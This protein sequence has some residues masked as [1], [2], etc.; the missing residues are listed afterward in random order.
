MSKSIKVM[1]GVAFTAVL[2]L[3]LLASVGDAMA[4][5]DTSDSSVLNGRGGRCPFGATWE[6]GG[7]TLG[8]TWE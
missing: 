8:A 3:S 6:K 5:T 2:V 1:R 7:C 4:K